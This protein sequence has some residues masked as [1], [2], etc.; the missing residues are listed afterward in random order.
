M[1]VNKFF[2][3][4]NKFHMIHWKIPYFTNKIAK[5]QWFAE[6]YFITSAGN[7][8]KQESFS[9]STSNIKKSNKSERD[10]DINV[11]LL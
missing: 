3:C 5:F 8:G 11:L 2:K 9:E 10:L 6:I 4:V 7:K 1:A